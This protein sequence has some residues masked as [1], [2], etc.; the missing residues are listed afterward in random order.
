MTTKQNLYLEWTDGN[1]LFEPPQYLISAKKLYVYPRIIVPSYKKNSFHSFAEIRV[2]CET[3]EL[4]AKKT[5]KK[6]KRNDLFAVDHNGIV[7]FDKLIIG[8]SITDKSE[9]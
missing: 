2:M 3:V 7:S 8:P 1:L 9:G 6:K 5:I 4:G